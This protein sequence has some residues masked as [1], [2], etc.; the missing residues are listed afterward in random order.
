M[1]VHREKAIRREG[2]FIEGGGDY[3]SREGP[4]VDVVGGKNSRLSGEGDS[5]REGHSSRGAVEKAVRRGGWRPFVGRRDRSSRAVR[6]AVHRGT[7]PFVEGGWRPFVQR[8]AVCRCCGK[9]E[10]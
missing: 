9:E 7:R 4:F 6:H 10:Q 2:P 8:G 5:S 3:W 1:A